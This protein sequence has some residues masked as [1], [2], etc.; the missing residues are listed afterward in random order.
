MSATCIVFDELYSNNKHA[1]THGST[2]APTFATK[3]NEVYFDVWEA[4]TITT[5]QKPKYEHIKYRDFLF[6]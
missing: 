3:T 1:R 2:H 4:K 5:T 6:A